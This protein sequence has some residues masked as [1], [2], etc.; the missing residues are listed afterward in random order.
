MA[1]RERG[2]EAAELRQIDEYSDGRERRGQPDRRDRPHPG[3]RGQHGPF[4][5]RPAAHPHDRRLAGVGP[6]SPA[7]RGRVELV[8]VHRRGLIPSR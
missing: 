1:D 8:V 5:H 2:A 4:G 6:Q 7:R 3:H